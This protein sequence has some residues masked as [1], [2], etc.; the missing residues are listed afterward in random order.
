MSSLT[1]RNSFASRYKLG[2][3]RKHL[4]ERTLKTVSPIPPVLIIDIDYFCLLLESKQKYS[5]TNIDCNTYIRQWI[6]STV[7]YVLPNNIMAV[8]SG[9]TSVW[10]E[11]VRNFF[12]SH[13]IPV[14]NTPISDFIFSA[15]L[16]GLI[17]TPAYIITNNFSTWAISNK[18]AELSFVAIDS[19]NRVLVYN[20]STGLDFFCKFIMTNKIIN[21]LG[22]QHIKYLNLQYLYVI[23]LYLNFMNQAPGTPFYFD[24]KFMCSLP[25]HKAKNQAFSRSSGIGL[26]LISQAHKFLS[27]AFLTKPEFMDLFLFS[28]GMDYT[29]HL[30]RLPKLISFD[31]AILDRLHTF[32]LANYKLNTIQLI[33]QQVIKMEQPDLYG[34]VLWSDISIPLTTLHDNAVRVKLINRYLKLYPSADVTKLSLTISP[35]FRKEIKRINKILPDIADT[36][37]NETDTYISS[38]LAGIFNG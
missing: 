14:Y 22:L 5:K 17:S 21:K 35:S 33:P 28:N 4:S 18:S 16:S 34:S 19:N 23:L 11:P 1:F 38:L 36:I 2:E 31:I 6:N 3:K 29:L 37:P 7:K 10:T 9:N 27:Y 32:Y 8:C 30:S 12:I 15:K 13:T 20:N 25:K 24:E 26:D